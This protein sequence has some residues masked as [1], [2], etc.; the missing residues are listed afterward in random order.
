MLLDVIATGSTGN[1]YVL[2]AG[3]DKLLLD[4]GVQWKRI[5]KALKFRTSDVAGC[6][7]THEHL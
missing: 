6:L 5:Q 4:C 2:T 7:I 3:K 1:C